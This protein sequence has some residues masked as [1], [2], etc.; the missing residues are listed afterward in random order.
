[1]SRRWGGIPGG[2]AAVVLLALAVA[3][4]RSR[5]LPPLVVWV[6][7]EGAP[8]QRIQS[9]ME[10]LGIPGKV[11]E[12]RE[13]LALR[14]SAM[15]GV[16][17]VVCFDGPL[18]AG[19]GATILPRVLEQGGS[20]LTAGEAASIMG[21][22]F[23]FEGGPSRGGELLWAAPARERLAP[24]TFEPST[25]LALCYGYGTKQLPGWRWAGASGEIWARDPNGAPR[26]VEVLRGQGR[27]VAAGLPLAQLAAGG[28]SLQARL[29]LERAAEL[30]GVA[31][32]WP[33]PRGRGA[34]LINV[35]VDSGFQASLLQ[36]LLDRWPRGVKGTFHL[37]AG[38]DCDAEG[39]GKG[40][41]VAGRELAWMKRL[42]TF[43][44]VASHGGWI[45]NVWAQQAEHWSSRELE[46]HLARNVRALAPWSEGRS[47]SSPAGTHPLSINPWLE[48]HGVRAYYH[49]GEGGCPPTRAWQGGRPFSASMWAFPVA[50]RGASASTFEF[51]ARG[52][53][54]REVAEWT[55]GLLDFCVDRREARMVYGHTVDFKEFPDA[56][57]GLLARLDRA[58]ADGRAESWTLQDYAEF[59]DR[60]ARLRWSFA[61]GRLRAAGASL[62]G[63]AFRLPGRWRAA[64]VGGL[65]VRQDGD[66]TW[67]IVQDGREALEINLW[68]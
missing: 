39:D 4:G 24:G 53:P 64:A 48:S 33:T 10:E 25:G 28:D 1:M 30:A 61:G 65:E 63:M 62:A 47:Y 18:G 5:E 27:L 17:A 34:L 56:Y 9:L 55:A 36:G 26:W 7:G 68:P 50:A 23:G 21:G 67:V 35:H 29:L 32:L 12:D 58:R 3:C 15:R 2:L 16:R 11:L 46:D 20:L 42:T 54:E 38:P 14:P 22:E 13:V 43:G 19:L 66:S 59:L 51:K 31:R 60:R 52:V 37:T 45:H 49:T 44:E 8:A 40:V 57:G 6:P 41:G